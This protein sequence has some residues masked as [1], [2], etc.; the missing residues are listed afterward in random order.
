MSKVLTECIVNGNRLAVIVIDEEKK[1]AAEAVWN[2]EGEFWETNFAYP[3]IGVTVNEVA[4]V[5]DYEVVD[6]AGYIIVE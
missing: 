5:M 2:T 4:E 6:E 3:A 1:E